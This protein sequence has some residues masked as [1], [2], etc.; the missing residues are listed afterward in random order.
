L[1]GSHLDYFRVNAPVQA[2]G[3]FGRRIIYFILILI[4]MPATALQDSLLLAFDH[5]FRLR[6]F[7]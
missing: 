3:G 7:W 6:C 4:I 1:N 5:W 2:F